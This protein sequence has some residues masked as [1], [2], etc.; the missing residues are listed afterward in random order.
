MKRWTKQSSF[1]RIGF[2]GVDHTFQYTKMKIM[3]GNGV[4]FEN[5]CQ[6]ALLNDVS[7]E[8]E[9]KFDDYVS[10]IGKRL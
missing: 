4:S 8:F 9:D 6:Y 10:S 2:T 1:E 5:V 3:N 7:M